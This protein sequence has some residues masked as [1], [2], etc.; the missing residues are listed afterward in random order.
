MSKLNTVKAY[1]K[2]EAEK[3]KRYDWRKLKKYTS[4]RA[5]D[6]LNRFLE[7]LPSHVSH[8]MLVTAAI[9]WAAAGVLGLYTTIQLKQ[10]TELRATFQDAQALTPIVPTIKDV[11][12]RPADVSK[13]VEEISEI[14]SGLSIKAQGATIDIKSSNINAFGQFREALGHVL[15][16]GVGWR[17]AINTM[18]IG[19]ECNKFPLSAT[20]KINKVSVNNPK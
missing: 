14:Y 18:C 11:A 13:F 3:A 20:L 4:P 12:V 17:V 6:D 1:I 2:S 5:A 16:G 15:N 10:L 19:R 8:S 9:A 7:G